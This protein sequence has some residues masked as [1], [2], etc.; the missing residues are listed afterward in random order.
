VSDDELEAPADEDEAVRARPF[1][2]NDES[3]SPSRDADHRSIF[4]SFVRILIILYVGKEEEEAL[5]IGFC[6]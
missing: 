4:F 3:S 5:S 1:S 2:A 6:T